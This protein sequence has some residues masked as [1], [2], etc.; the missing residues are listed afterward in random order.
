MIYSYNEILLSHNKNEILTHATTWMN[1]EHMVSE[2][3]QTK[4]TPYC[5]S[6]LYKIYRIGK[7]IGVESRLV[8]LPGAEGGEIGDDY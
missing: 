8:V 3:R 6:H 4:K 7:S 1:L 5:V 2:R